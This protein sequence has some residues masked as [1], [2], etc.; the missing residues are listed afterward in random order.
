LF[1]LLKLLF[2]FVFT[3]GLVWFSIFDSGKNKKGTLNFCSSKR[4]CFMPCSIARKKKFVNH[5]FLKNFF[6][7]KIQKRDLQ[8]K[9]NEL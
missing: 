3:Y 4:L 7:K 8:I 6:K 5:F 1:L 2:K 9:K